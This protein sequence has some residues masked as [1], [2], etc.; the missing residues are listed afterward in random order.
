MNSP[1]ELLNQTLNI[2][3]SV[4]HHSGSDELVHKHTITYREPGAEAAEIIRRRPTTGS[5]PLSYAR[6]TRSDQST[7]QRG[8][9]RAQS[10]LGESPVARPSTAPVSPSRPDVR[11]PGSVQGSHDVNDRGLPVAGG[12]RPSSRSGH[13]AAPN[14]SALSGRNV[15]TE[16]PTAKWNSY[17]PPSQ[18][19]SSQSLSVLC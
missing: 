8:S 15:G 3:V 5:P 4:M 16:S 12:S 9:H 2:T 14:L 1:P 10:Y 17:V 18:V 6:S 13:V 19:C 11:S 7:P